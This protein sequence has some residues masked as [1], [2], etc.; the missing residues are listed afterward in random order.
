MRG[1]AV[2]TKSLADSSS[3]PA[4]ATLLPQS[5]ATA[6]DSTAVTL[7][8]SISSVS[9]SVDVAITRTRTAVDAQ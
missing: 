6:M 8:A 2:L 9:S 5:I 4:T 7:T 3:T 1:P